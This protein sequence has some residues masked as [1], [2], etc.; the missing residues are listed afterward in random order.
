MACERAAAAT[1]LE[2]QPL[3]PAYLFEMTEH[4]GG[5][6]VGV[7]TEAALVHERQIVVVVGHGRG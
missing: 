7:V 4:A 2:D 1:E 3:S 6:G 5:T